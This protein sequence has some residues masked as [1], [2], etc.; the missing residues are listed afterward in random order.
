MVTRN[1]MCAII[2]NS[3]VKRY[4]TTLPKPGYVYL[5][6]PKWKT[7]PLK[8]LTAEGFDVDLSVKRR[9][10]TK[11]TVHA[12]VWEDDLGN[13]HIDLKIEHDPNE[14]THLSNLYYD[15]AGCIRHELEHITDESQLAGLGPLQEIV[16][17]HVPN[18]SKIVHTI[19]RR[20]KMFGDLYDNREAWGREE[21]RRLDSAIDGNMLA[22]LTCF[23]EVG[24][25]TQGFYYEAKKRR[26]STEQVI[27]SY[28]TSLQKGGLLSDEEADEAFNHLAA[29]TKMTL[30][31]AI[32]S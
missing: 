32:M 22:Y 17:P 14:K 23:E 7:D 28:I 9:K 24:P 1:I 30:P 11:F 29:W 20:Y 3:A 31:N 4:R 19:N 10:G 2:E 25:L 13:S 15:L 6:D 12:S 26:V 16:V 18:K 8:S 27:D 21:K 5:W